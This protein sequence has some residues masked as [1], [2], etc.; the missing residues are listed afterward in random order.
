M[1]CCITL[2]YCSPTISYLLSL[3]CVLPQDLALVPLSSQEGEEAASSESS[4]DSESEGE[5]E[6]E[7]GE[8]V[9]VFPLKLPTSVGHKRRCAAIEEL[10]CR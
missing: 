1:Y 2:A 6:R 8:E 9:K 7:G 5:G 10:P 4:S 3:L